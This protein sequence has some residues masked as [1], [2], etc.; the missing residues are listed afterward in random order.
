[1]HYGWISHMYCIICK[2]FV[3]VI[4]VCVVCVSMFYYTIYFVRISKKI[5]IGLYA[6][7]YLYIS[8]VCSF[9]F[10]AFCTISIRNI[11][12]LQCFPFPFPFPF[13]LRGS[14]K[15]Y[16]FLEFPIKQDDNDALSLFSRLIE[17]SKWPKWRSWSKRMRTFT[18]NIII[19]GQS[20]SKS[21]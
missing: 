3:Y 11:C 14:I 15:S 2:V 8:Y 4:M 16:L 18:K 12:M 1:M 21:Y 19:Y 10:L 5:S 20:V 9:C 7:W 6:F 17:Q 13:Y